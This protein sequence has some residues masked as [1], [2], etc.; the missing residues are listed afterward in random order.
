MEGEEGAELGAGADGPL[1]ALGEEQ[2]GMPEKVG[3]DREMLEE[4]E[5]D[6][7]KNREGA[8]PAESG[9]EEETAAAPKRPGVRLEGGV[10]E[11]EAT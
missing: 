9:R 8:E 3:A 11:E 6:S 1:E 10:E 4:E 2:R 5:E 7:D